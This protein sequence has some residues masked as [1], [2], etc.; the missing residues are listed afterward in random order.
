MLKTGIFACAIC[1]AGSD[2]L[3]AAETIQAE[4][5]TNAQ[6]QAALKAA[7]DNTIIE[8]QGQQKTKAELRSELQAQHKPFDTAKAKE[9]AEQDRSKFQAAAKALQDQQDAAVA[10]ENAAVDAEFE[11]LK[12]R[13]TPAN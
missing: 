11:K 1:L 7:P 13:E 9:A 3:H 10:A 5:L 4:K 2:P 6:L 8:Y 12:A